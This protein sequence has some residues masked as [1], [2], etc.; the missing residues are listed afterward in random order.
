MHVQIELGIGFDCLGGNPNGW[1]EDKERRQRRT[2]ETR[3]EIEDKLPTISQDA[4]D[5]A[6]LQNGEKAIFEEKYVYIFRYNS[7]WLLM[8]AGP[9][10]L[11]IVLFPPFIKCVG[12]LSRELKWAS[13]LYAARRRQPA[14]WGARWR[15]YLAPRL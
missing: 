14:A 7:Q 9:C 3:G 6:D 12:F 1:E 13:V 11:L 5:G 2:V 10:V 15:R 8:Y 4:E